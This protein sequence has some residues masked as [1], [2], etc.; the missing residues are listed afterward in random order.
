VQLAVDVM[1][2]TPPTLPDWVSFDSIPD[3]FPTPLKS[4]GI[5]VDLVSFVCGTVRGVEEGDERLGALESWRGN[6]WELKTG[7]MCVK[8]IDCFTRPGSVQ[9]VNPI[10]KNLEE[11]F[12]RIR[13]WE[14]RNQLIDLNIITPVPPPTSSIVVVDPFSSGSNLAAMVVKMGYHLIMVFSTST[15]PLKIQ[16]GGDVKEFFVPDLS[17]DAIAETVRELEEQ[18]FPIQAIL[19]GAETGVELADQLANAMGVRCNPLQYCEARRSKDLMQERIKE[20]GIR[21]IHGCQSSELEDL[22]SFHDSL[23]SIKCIV[24]P[25]RSAG[26]DDVYVCHSKEEV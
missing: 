18:P 21:S 2:P 5:E 15:I 25:L 9:L 19:P 12:D 8:T 24:K 22:F 14:K 11:D 10:R 20:A 23:S 3:K 13:V 17:P 7:E 1:L 26:S 4:Y 6:C 16:I